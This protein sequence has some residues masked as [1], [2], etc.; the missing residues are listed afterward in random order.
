MKI[1]RLLYV[2]MLLL[3]T[4][5]LGA[6]A[7]PPPSLSEPLNAPGFW[8]TPTVPGYGRIHYLPQAHYLPDK[9]K[10]YKVV[11][12]LTKAAPSPDKVNPA[13]DHIARAVNLYVAAGVP[14]SH[15]KFVGIAYGPAT[16]LAIDNEHYRAKFGVDNPNLKLVQMLR[17]DGVDI[18]VCAQAVAE[19]GFQE[20][21]VSPDV[22]LALAGLTT[23]I[24]LQQAGYALMPM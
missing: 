19:H 22:T 21:W 14:V 6:L 1:P 15:L 12:A 17:K 23:V 13:L 10:T 20:N 4:I 9:N 5:S 16:A 8:T 3:A 24:D 2:P 18:A 11:F 7:A